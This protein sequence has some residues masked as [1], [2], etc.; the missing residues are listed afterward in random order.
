MSGLTVRPPL[1]MLAVEKA[2]KILAECVRVDEAK[3]IRDKAAALVTYQRQQKA[4]EEAQNDAA[5]IKLRAE[6]RIGELL[7][8]MAEEGERATAG[9]RGRPKKSGHDGRSSVER[10]PTYKELEI[11]DRSA[12][13]WQEIARV[14][15]AKFEEHIRE[16]RAKPGAEITSAGIR[17]DLVTEVRRSDR[18]AKIVESARQGKAGPL[19][20]GEKFA[21]IYADPAWEYEQSGGNGAAA[22][23][24]PTMPIEKI[25]ALE[26]PT[27]CTDAAICFLWATNPLLP[28]AL[29]V[30]AAWDFAYKG[31]FAA[32]KDRIGTGF[33]VRGKHELLLF[34]VRGDFPTPP[35]DARPESVF[36]FEVGKHSEKPSIAASIIERMYPELPRV[37]L[38]A[39]S[40]RRGWSRWGLEAPSPPEVSP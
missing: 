12:R 37:E 31:N 3:S 20:R 21:V 2:R 36:P 25:R 35:T 22:G 11:P 4:G 26:V 13:R 30:L 27:I 7:I 10:A 28:E 5:E 14:P 8:Q 9:D 23:H 17:R 6:R 38:F 40:V 24:Y 19:P 32:V 15:A 16:T 1:G 39:R 34:G 29:S 33:W 18:V